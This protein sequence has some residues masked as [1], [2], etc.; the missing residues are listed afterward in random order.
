MSVIKTFR[1]LIAWQ[2]AIELAL[3]VCKAAKQM[4]R[5]EPFGLTNQM[6]R[7]AVSAQSNIA[8]GYARQSRLDYRKFLRT[9]SSSLAE[10]VTQYELTMSL[11][12]LKEE[13]QLTGL[14]KEED[15]TLPGLIRSL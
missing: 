13:K 10:L 9:A 15:R 7:V 6:R 11:N 14:L 1:D 8:E 4:P 2:K 12:M 5:T 3:A